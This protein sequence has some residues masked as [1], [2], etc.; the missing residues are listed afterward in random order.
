MMWW[1]CDSH[2][3]FLVGEAT[4]VVTVLLILPTWRWYVC[5]EIPFDI[6]EFKSI[7]TQKVGKKIA[8]SSLHKAKDAVI[9]G[10]V[11]VRQHHLTVREFLSRDHDVIVEKSQFFCDKRVILLVDSSDSGW[12]TDRLMPP[13]AIQHSTHHHSSS[14]KRWWSLSFKLIHS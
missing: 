2:F 8:N 4:E 5:N 6:V 3:P 13:S 10:E 7:G 14:I 9:K 12:L 11:V 1:C